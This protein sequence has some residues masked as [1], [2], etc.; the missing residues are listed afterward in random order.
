MRKHLNDRKTCVGDLYPVEK[1]A[2]LTTVEAF[3]HK[4]INTVY[5][6]FIG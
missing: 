1:K 5:T 3:A 2:E 6:V 4:I